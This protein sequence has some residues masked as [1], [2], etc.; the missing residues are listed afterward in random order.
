MAAPSFVQIRKDFVGKSFSGCPSLRATSFYRESNGEAIMS[1]VYIVITNRHGPD[2]IT[3]KHAWPTS[4]GAEKWAHELRKF[5]GC[6]LDAV[7]VV[8]FSLGDT[9]DAPR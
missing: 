7:Q 6:S 2:E 3:A 4:D 5:L 8:Y 9:L 1:G